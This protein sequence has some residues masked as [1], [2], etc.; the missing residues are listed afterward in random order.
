[1][2]IYQIMPATNK[3]TVARHSNNTSSNNRTT[4]VHACICDDNCGNSRFNSRTNNMEILLIE[5]VLRYECCC[6]PLAYGMR[7]VYVGMCGTNAGCR[8]AFS[9]MWSLPKR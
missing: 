3:C 6:V 1:M 4:F 7:L 8:V 2:M 9:I 5:N